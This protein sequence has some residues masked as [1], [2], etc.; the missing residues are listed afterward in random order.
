V[1]NQ[2]LVCTH[3]G[4]GN[5]LFQILYARLL[6]EKYG[7]K[8]ITYFHAS[9]YKRK[10]YFEL[11]QFD[12]LELAQGFNKLLLR[13]RLPKIFEKLKLS[14]SGKIKLLNR[15]ILDSYFQ[16]P[17]LYRKISRSAITTQI[18][19]FRKIIL[20][21]KELSF[22]Y[23][24]KSI[25]HLRL[26]DFFN[27]ESEQILFIKTQTKKI[28]SNSIVISN[29]DDLFSSKEF[30]SGNDFK[31]NYLKTSQF[32]S[33]T[34]ILLFSS[35]SKVSTNGSTLAFWGAIFGE[36]DL[37]LNNLNNSHEKKLNEMYTLFKL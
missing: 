14:N 9:K 25:F 36:A 12:N 19:E 7:V 35:F 30:I 23:K 8:K 3:G 31:I 27:S 32:D 15:I 29:R 13:L 20:L 24:T 18:K 34:L 11:S 16:E 1:K 26:G 21:P 10:A 6:S 4:I 33:L 28:S 2:I 5:Q 22:D 17:C 37:V